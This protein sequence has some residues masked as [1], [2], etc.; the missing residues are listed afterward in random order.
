MAWEAQS[1]RTG[2]L[3]GYERF[4]N[5]VQRV[6]KR[7]KQPLTWAEIKENRI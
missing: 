4:R 5:S 1:K 6:L 7:A 2:S 3:R